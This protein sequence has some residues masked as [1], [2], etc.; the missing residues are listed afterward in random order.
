M[1][2]PCLRLPFY[3]KTPQVATPVVR[4]VWI[5]RVIPVFSPAAGNH[6]V[7]DIYV[8]SV[9]YLD[10]PTHLAKPRRIWYTVH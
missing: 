2:K 4:V 10:P 1:V 8:D 3:P 5:G 6:N 7:F 9:F